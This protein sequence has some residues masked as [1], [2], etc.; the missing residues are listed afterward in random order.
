MRD[1][2]SRGRKPRHL[3]RAALSG[4]LSL[5]DKGVA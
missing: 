1:E 2:D 3:A 4:Y 5:S